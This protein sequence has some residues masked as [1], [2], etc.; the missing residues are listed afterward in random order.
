LGHEV[1]SF[2]STEELLRL[3]PL[4]RNRYTRYLGR[5]AFALAMNLKLLSAAETARPDVV[6]VIKGPYVT[7]W[8]LKRIRSQT[9]AKLV[10]LNPD[11][12]L[13]PDFTTRHIRRTIPLYDC[14]FTFLRDIILKLRAAG[15]PR[16][17]YLPFAYDPEI[18]RAVN[19]SEDEQSRW[20]HDVVFVGAWDRDR[21][22]WLEP[23]ADFD[24]GIWGSHWTKL[25]ARSPLMRCVRGEGIFGLGMARI[26][27]ASKIVLNNL[28][29]QGINSH[30]MRTFEVPACGA[31][32]LTQRSAGQVE[33][34]AEGREIECYANIVELREKVAA[35]LAD[36]HARRRI[37]EAGHEAVRPHTYLERAAKAIEVVRELQLG[38]AATPMC[39][40]P[41]LAPILVSLPR[42]PVSDV[43]THAARVLFLNP[44]APGSYQFTLARGLERL[45]F[46]I[47][48]ISLWSP[49]SRPIAQAEIRVRRQFPWLADRTI[50]PAI[51]NFDGDV[52]IVV[53]GVQ[54]SSGALSSLARMGKKLVNVYPDSAGRLLYPADRST[55]SLWSLITLK[56][57]HAVETLRSSGLTNIRYLPQ[58]FDMDASY[59]LPNINVPAGATFI[60]HL[61]PDRASWVE[62]LFEAQVRI[63]GRSTGMRVF[64]KAN[65]ALYDKFLQCHRGGSVS[66]L[67]KLSFYARSDVSINIHRP[68][69]LFGI[70]KR[71]FDICGM[72]GCQIVDWRPTLSE[73][74]VPGK[75]VIA[76]E[77]PGELPGRVRDILKRWDLRR[78]IAEAGKARA[79]KD[80]RNDL[81][82]AELMNLIEE[83]R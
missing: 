35:Y 6:F 2:D 30:N 48:W 62:A 43:R 1:F 59:E 82:A 57:Q 73:Y 69:E 68:D 11:N 25:D 13:Y 81:R 54:I 38:S 45:G 16:A 29:S 28:R 19:P 18:H 26:L 75:E 7:P 14:Y 9:G 39:P 64:R 23:L 12:P 42:Q 47:H 24:L 49:R 55:L 10:N 80:H 5:S 46:E 50:L 56:D 76:V 3:S 21:E 83:I 31:F 40:R 4:A 41:P 53:K 22:A 65:P 8:A 37:A 63:Y 32:E 79:F 78:E 72:G 60:A 66:E 61:D 77:G 44:P 36:E 67:E 58:C 74:F 34:F 17:E 70:N 15:S 52:L 71:T 20:G 33:F 51:S 27:S